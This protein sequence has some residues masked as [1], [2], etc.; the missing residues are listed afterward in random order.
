M[1]GKWGYNPVANRGLTVLVK[2]N[3]EVC[4]YIYICVCVCVAI[5]LFNIAMENPL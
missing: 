5:W 2:V 4:I 3:Y 1:V